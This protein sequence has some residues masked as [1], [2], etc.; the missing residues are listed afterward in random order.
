MHSTWC[1]F[2]VL[3][4]IIDAKTVQISPYCDVFRTV[5][6]FSEPTARAESAIYQFLTDAA[7]SKGAMGAGAGVQAFVRDAQPFHRPT[8]DQMFGNNFRGI[9]GIHVPI[10]DGFRINHDHRAMLALVQA[11]GLVD[12]HLPGQTGSLGELLQADVQIA[13]SVG[14]AGSPRRIRWPG[15]EADKDVAFEG[16][17]A[18]LLW[19]VGF[20]RVLIGL[21]QARHPFSD[22][23]RRDAGNCMKPIC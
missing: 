16:G 10:P 8:A 20:R 14:G 19:G 11:A 5:F 21:Y 22:P 12:A 1:T 4:A 6:R 23:P 3:C 15:V 13:G 18:F 9:V 2:A 7:G 17:Q